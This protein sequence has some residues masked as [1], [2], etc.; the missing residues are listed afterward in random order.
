MI[1]LADTSIWVD[2]LRSGSRGD[3]SDLDGL[4]K[5]GS[6]VV[7]GPV[8]A[9]LLAGAR[10]NDRDRLWSLFRTLPWAH[11]SQDEWQRVGETSA[12]LRE[13]GVTVPLT[14]VQIAVCALA[15]EAR[16]WTLDDDFDRISSVL[17][18]LR[19]YQPS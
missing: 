19:Q 17:S 10:S 7:C 18:E 4:L 5:G 16:L 12:L 1:V 6:I 2:Y 15:A 14:D 9:E 11:L 3:T 13:D 8:V